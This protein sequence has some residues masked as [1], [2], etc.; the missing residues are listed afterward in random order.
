[1]NQEPFHPPSF[2]QAPTEDDPVQFPRLTTACSFQK[3][4]TRQNTKKKRT[5]NEIDEE[6]LPPLPVR[7][8]CAVSFVVIEAVLSK[9]A[10]VSF[11]A[12]LAARSTASHA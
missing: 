3:K 4:N 11:Y 1:M 9:I 12:W 6:N 5:M 7:F 10:T 2:Y 8:M